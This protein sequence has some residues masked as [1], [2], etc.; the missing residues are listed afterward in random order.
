MSPGDGLPMTIGLTCPSRVFV[1]SSSFDR[2]VA[3]GPVNRGTNTS[4]EWVQYADSGKGGLYWCLT[5]DVG[6]VQTQETH[7]RGGS[8]EDGERRLCNQGEK[9]NGTT[10]LTEVARR[11]VPSNVQV[12]EM[13]LSL[14]CKRRFQSRYNRHHG[15]WRHNPRL[16][17]LSRMWNTS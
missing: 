3:G 12:K 10:C 7:G 1:C 11:H 13:S 5:D 6:S 14:G 17:A 16:D 4:S 9:D 15:V 2:L 8:L